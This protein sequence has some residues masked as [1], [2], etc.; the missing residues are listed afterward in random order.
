MPLTPE[1]RA[2]RRE[3]RRSDREQRKQRPTARNNL[4]GYQTESARLFALSIQSSND[5]SNLVNSSNDSHTNLDSSYNSATN[6]R[7]QSHN[8]NLSGISEGLD[9]STE[10]NR[11]TMQPPG[12]DAAQGGSPRHNRAGPF[13]NDSDDDDYYGGEEGENNNGGNP[14]LD[15]SVEGGLEFQPAKLDRSASSA[16]SGRANEGG[17]DFFDTDD[18]SPSK[19]RPPLLVASA[20]TTSSSATQRVANTDEDS[21]RRTARDKFMEVMHD[22]DREETTEDYGNPGPSPFDDDS[23][24]Q[25]SQGSYE[26]PRAFR[27]FSGGS[28]QSSVTGEHY[29]SM[30]ELLEEERSRTFVNQ[31]TSRFGGCVDKV[32]GGKRTKRRKITLLM[33]VLL[34][35]AVIGVS[36]YVVLSDPKGSG[37]DKK[38]DVD[39]QN[40]QQIERPGTN[41][42]PINTGN[43]SSADSTFG[44]ADNSTDDI[45]DFEPTFPDG[46][47]P[48]NTTADSTSPMASPG[49]TP[50]TTSD[51]TLSENIPT[52]FKP[53]SPP[54]DSPT[55]PVSEF[56][57]AEPVNETNQPTGSPASDL[58][59]LI[60]AVEIKLRA[61]D[62]IAS[63]FGHD[64]IMY[65]QPE[66]PPASPMTCSEQF[67]G[68]S[69]PFDLWTSNNLSFV[70]EAPDDEVVSIAGNYNM[71]LLEFSPRTRIE[72][73]L[74]TPNC[75]AEYQDIDIETITLDFDDGGIGH[76]QAY[77]F[78]KGN[79]FLEL[80]ADCGIFTRIQL[81]PT[82]DGI[83]DV[84]FKKLTVTALY[85][86]QKVAQGLREYTWSTSSY[87][88][89]R[90][91]ED[92]SIELENVSASAANTPFQSTGSP[93]AAPFVSTPSDM[94]DPSVTVA[95]VSVPSVQTDIGGVLTFS[96]PVPQDTEAGLIIFLDALKKSIRSA[97]SSSLQAND[98][99]VYVEILSINGE[100]V[101]SLLLRRRFI[102]RRLQFGTSIE[103]EIVVLTDC[104]SP[105]CIESDTVGS[106]VFSRTTNQITSSV[107]SGEFA[108][109]LEVNVLSSSGGSVE[110]VSGVEVGD[111]SQPKVTVLIPTGDYGVNETSPTNS[112]EPVDVIAA[113]E[114]DPVG[115]SAT[116]DS[117]PTMNNCKFCEDGIPDPFKTVSDSGLTCNQLKEAVSDKDSESSTCTTVKQAE[118]LCCE[119]SSTASET[120]DEVSS[121]NATFAGNETLLTNSTDEDFGD[122]NA[123]E[124]PFIGGNETLLTN[125]TGEDI[126]D[127]NA[128]F[129]GNE[130][131]LTNSTDEDFGDMNATESPFI[132]G[133]ETL[134][135]NSTGEDIVDMNATFPGN[136]T[137]LTNSTDEDF[138]DMNATESPAI[139]GNETLL[140]NS[141]GEDIAEII[142]FNN[143]SGNDLAEGNETIS[144]NS[145]SEDFVI[146]DTVVGNETFVSYEDMPII[147]ENGTDS[148][149]DNDALYPDLS[150]PATLTRSI[151]IDLFASLFYEVL[152]PSS[153]EARNGIFCARLQVK[154]LGWIGF[155]LSKDGSMIGSDAIIAHPDDNT[156]FKYSL[157]GKSTDLLRKVDDDHQTLRDTSVTQDLELGVTTM[158]FVKHLDEFEEIPILLEGPN[159]FLYAR[160]GSNF[161]GYHLGRMHFIHDFAED[162]VVVDDASADLSNS[163]GPILL[164]ST[165][166][167]G[168]NG[169]TSPNVT[170]LEDVVS[171][172]YGTNYTVSTT[173]S[174]ANTCK[175]CEEGI[176]DPFL[177]VSDSG[178]NCNQL[179]DA[180]SDEDSDSNTC[181]AVKQAEDLCCELSSTVSDT[182]DE[183]S[184]STSN[185]V[186]GNETF[187]PYGD[188]PFIDENGTYS[189]F[190]LSDGNETMS[191]NSTS[192]DFV[193]VD[194][195][196]G[197]E[198]FVSYGDE[199]V[200]DENGN[201]SYFGND[202][203]YPD[204]NSTLDDSDG[205]S[206]SNNV[207]MALE[208]AQGNSTLDDTSGSVNV[209]DVT[210]PLDA[211]SFPYTLSNEVEGVSAAARHGFSVAMSSDGNI[212]AVGAKDMTDAVLGQVG[213]VHLYSM[214]SSPPTLIQTLVNTYPNGEFGNSIGLSNDGN[215]LVVGARSENDQTGVVRVYG[216]D[217]FGQWALMGMPINGL[218]IGERAGW[219]VSISGDGSSVAVGAPKG[220]G[221]A[222]GS[223][224]TYRFENGSNWEQYGSA[225]QGASNE[226]F[227]YTTS[228]SYDGNLVA[229]GSPKAMNSEGGSNAG[230]ASVFYVYGTEWLPLPATE[231]HGISSNDIDG[232]S[233]AL[234]QDGAILVVG[235]KG[236]DNDD[237]DRNAGH[238]RIYE[239]GT[240]WDLLHSM[241]GQT[242]NERLGS[243][244]AVSKNG[245]VVAC[246]GEGGMYDGIGMGVVRTWNRE[247]SQSSTLWPRTGDSGA[248]FGSALSLKEDG[249]ILVVGAP[250]RNSMAIGSKAGA[251]DVY[252]DFI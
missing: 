225:L 218:S 108:S 184:S 196:V 244:V 34:L 78:E 36:V 14:F 169:T 168:I 161:L 107:V 119:L 165:F 51:S 39:T 149:F 16:K 175:F 210:D 110:Y 27:P 144:S 237:G 234:S 54:S 220:G 195:V 140:T 128:T 91:P 250:E 30:Q 142:P 188:K 8:R 44:M 208:D 227:G 132:G 155:A 79:S 222:S 158:E 181:M 148:G 124:S 26:Q 247:T 28:Q 127:M 53:T 48:P 176:S 62:S 38:K 18:E 191:S 179:K 239:F 47:K 1:E 17:G 64:D 238:C 24:D 70:W 160:G 98:E 35:C 4:Q 75:Q 11:V 55:P 185:S 152:R 103:Y 157:L 101:E 85:D 136:E 173:V 116:D 92:G 177:V 96:E 109:T 3:A 143:T 204:V 71:E 25:P 37:G 15:D 215:R 80:Q 72:L 159:N 67:C 74:K 100:P 130:T 76:T 129:S 123:T 106:D 232:T 203:F 115:S 60:P 89:M 32:L 147:Y 41:F 198:T 216:R 246:G 50:A 189:G 213:G 97:V 113:N 221:S 212:L 226:A 69:L 93:S 112:T 156:V 187:V 105:E 166:E 99:L 137:L 214:E 172:G 19:P 7:R 133:N 9:N 114:T 10:D 186:D 230:K 167:D 200:M 163:S 65:F 117:T 138:G 217:T 241:E 86:N 83:L 104:Y 81:E 61:N 88:W 139:G 49:S 33:I 29:A 178:L 58:V 5:S 209:S 150:C 31:K 183:T 45:F 153:L 180:V 233:I 193:I 219:S 249:K 162:V 146:I 190:D 95:P 223:V 205:N 52:E 170:E 252:R 134:P 211:L 206:T 63:L 125:S 13:E 82:E 171:D 121:M 56:I 131:L 87:I 23:V 43:V 202:A 240:D 243:S 229:V 57:P 154:S 248:L 207:A 251:V 164:N 141:T 21:N 90:R 94:S 182:F 118:G 145:T 6:N 236:A 228:L 235:G 201:Y 2:A 194:T 46:S 111:F 20:L 22:G 151:E 242:E 68:G 42:V 126:V 73:E 231:I 102:R 197:N 66:E 40:M 245:N 192:E 224:F 84:T 174:S 122:M 59:Q 199:P 135:T 77:T 12:Q 120:I